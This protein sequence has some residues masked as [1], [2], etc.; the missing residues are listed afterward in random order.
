MDCTGCVAEHVVRLKVTIC[1]GDREALVR[2]TEA[3]LAVERQRRKR[4]Y[5][6]G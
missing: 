6:R 5:R 1:C 2:D 4:L 3:G